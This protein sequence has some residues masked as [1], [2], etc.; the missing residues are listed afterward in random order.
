MSSILIDTNAY[1]AY[2]LSDPVVLEAIARSDALYV[3]AIT[4]GEL[5]AGFRNGSRVD[6]NLKV[7][8]RFLEQP[9]VDVLAVTSETARIYGQLWAACKQQ[10]RPAPVNDLWI[11]SHA[12]QTDAI[13]VTYDRHFLQVPQVRCWPHLENTQP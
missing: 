11:A 4:L 8:G 12:V 7:L 2:T 3:S 5:H 9:E 10:G 6:K 13:L 1:T